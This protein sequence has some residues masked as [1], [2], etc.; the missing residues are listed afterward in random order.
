VK[1]ASAAL[2][3]VPALAPA[4][5]QEDAQRWKAVEPG[6]ELVFPRDHGAHPEYRTEWWYVT[7]EVRDASGARFGFQFTVFRSG[8]DARAGAPDDSPL[9]ARQALAGHLAVT[10]VAGGRTLFAER[11]R[12]TGT[13]LASAAEGELDLVL[14][15]WSFRRSAD[16]RLSLRASDPA[17]GIGLEL[18]LVPAKPLVL[19]GERGVSSKGG[20]GNASAYVS[21]TR[22]GVRGRLAVGNGENGEGRARDV[23]GSAWFDHEFGSSFLAE[24]V[25]GWDWFGLELDDGRDLMVFE[26]RAAA[27]KGTKGGTWVER[28]GSTRA[29]EPQD[30]EIVP[31]GRWKSPRSGAEY[32]ARWTIRVGNDVLE[33]VPLV[34]DCELDTS[35]T[36]GV[37][38]WEGPVEVRGAAT[39]RGYAEL[40]GYA[41]GLEPR[42]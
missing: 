38:Y 4:V 15:D 29:L 35:A 34:A 18:E 21:W 31:A 6:L 3:L 26:L 2:A 40:T 5:N 14:E 24:G 7:G 10:D 1:W 19:H 23:E 8:L 11:L 39:G 37:V 42:F 25:T 32:P 27:A 16:D 30:F 13:P 9:R 17:A 22:L 12:R 41:E 20:P 33:V 28:D 36:T